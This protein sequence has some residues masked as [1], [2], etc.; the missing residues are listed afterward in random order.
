MRFL[1]TLILAKLAFY[2]GIVAAAAFAKRAL[3]SRGDAESDEVGLVAILGGVEL[4][5]RSQAFRGGSMLAWMG[6]I[7]ADL[8]G[9]QLAPTAHLTVH[10]LMGGIEITVP[11]GW[12]VESSTRA[13]AGGVQVDVPE[14]AD[15]AAPMLTLDG[16]AAFGGVE[17]RARAPL[18]AEA[19]G[20]LASDKG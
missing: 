9:V 16:L 12:R 17:V 10:T 13:L 3:P 14:P 4:E 6:G 7:E 2:G 15:P 8:R 19:S 20:T 5:S 11:E 18:T 1:R